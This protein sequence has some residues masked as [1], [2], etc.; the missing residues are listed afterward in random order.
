MKAVT[1]FFRS[2]T[3]GESGKSMGPPLFPSPKGEGSDQSPRLGDLREVVVGVAE[4]GVDHGDALE[5]VTDL[6]L[7]RHAAPAMELDRLLADEAAGAAD[8]DLRG[9]DRLAALRGVFV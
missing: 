3:R 6:E 1:C 8:L 4:E 7:H 9:R 2:S 5:V